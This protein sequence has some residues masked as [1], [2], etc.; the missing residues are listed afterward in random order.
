MTVQTYAAKK[1]PRG[2]TFIRTRARI[3]R[4]IIIIQAIVYILPC[5][6]LTKLIIKMFLFLTGS[7]LCEF[8]L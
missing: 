3:S 8:L 7:C 4:M 6:F 1:F 5:H 2:I